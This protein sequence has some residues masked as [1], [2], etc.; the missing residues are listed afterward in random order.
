MAQVSIHL[1]DVLLDPS[2]VRDAAAVTLETA[3]SSEKDEGPLFRVGA[4]PFHQNV[5]F[6]PGRRHPLSTSGK[7]TYSGATLGR[8]LPSF[9]TARS[10][11]YPAIILCDLGAESY[12]KNLV[13]MK[14]G[15]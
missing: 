10:R 8:I 11:S 5:A 4:A 15:K 12:R 1:P 3:S 6:E 2:N 14:A 9:S 7:V 13:K